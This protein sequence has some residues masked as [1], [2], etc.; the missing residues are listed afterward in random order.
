MAEITAVQ[1]LE[2]LRS[3]AAAAAGTPSQAAAAP[4]GSTGFADLFVK[5]IN[6]VDAAQQQAQTL[7]D[8]FQR[9]DPR[10]DLS[11]VMIASQKAN[12]EFQLLMQVRNRV[13]NAYQEIM[14]MQI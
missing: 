9:G 3:M 4:E 8:G 11:Q 6:Q 13:I 2:Q 10:I 7:R 5:A 14:N 1:L 12:I